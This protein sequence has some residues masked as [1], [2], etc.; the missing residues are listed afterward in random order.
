MSSMPDSIIP[1]PFSTIPHKK[2]EHM[3]L[4]PHPPSRR[5]TP[6][7]YFNSIV[8][9]SSGAAFVDNWPSMMPIPLFSS[10]CVYKKLLFPRR[11][12]I[13]CC[14]AV[15]DELFNSLN[16]YQDNDIMSSRLK[17]ICFD[18]HTIFTHPYT[19]QK[20]LHL[21]YIIYLADLP[22]MSCIN[23]KQMSLNYFLISHDCFGLHTNITHPDEN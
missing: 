3:P 15:W 8:F 10:T 11:E 17:K 13:Y 21:V 22:P 2:V 19:K 23:N 12:K 1:H 5:L 18:P 9:A 6:K 14:A 7:T 4:F 16:L 20:Q